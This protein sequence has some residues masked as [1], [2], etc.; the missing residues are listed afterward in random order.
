MLFLVQRHLTSGEVSETEVALDWQI[1][2][3]FHHGEFANAG[4]SSD[5]HS[6]GWPLVAWSE[7]SQVKRRRGSTKALPVSTELQKA[8]CADTAT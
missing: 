8:S 4:A 2:D 5:V 3:C 1:R 6:A 7:Q